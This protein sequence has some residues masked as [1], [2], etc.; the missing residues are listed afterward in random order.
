MGLVI[1]VILTLTER[2][3]GKQ[4]VDMDGE[5]IGEI[6]EFERGVAYV[7]PD[8]NLPEP[9]RQDVEQEA[10]SY[11]LKNTMVHSVTEEEIRIRQ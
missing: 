1:R 11:V 10:G 8:E 6:A 7:D 3:E 5:R 2:D 4:V 9:L